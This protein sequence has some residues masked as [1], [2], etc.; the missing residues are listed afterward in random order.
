MID[1]AS[2]QTINC[3]SCNHPAKVCSGSCQECLHEIHYWHN[4]PKPIRRDCY[5]CDRL[6]F[7]Y[8]KSY[9]ERYYQNILS[10]CECIDLSQFDR[11][12]ILSIG[13]GASPDLMAFEE[14]ARGRQIFYR[15]IDKIDQWHGFHELIMSY[16]N[17]SNIT[18]DFQQSDIFNPVGRKRT[19]IFNVVVMQYLISSIWCGLE[20]KGRSRSCKEQEVRKV[21][22]GVIET[23]LYRWSESRCPTPFLIIINDNDSAS[24]GR[25]QFY[26]LLDMLVENDYY[27][28]AYINSNFIQDDMSD[29]DNKGF[30]GFDFYES[31][32]HSNRSATLTIEVRK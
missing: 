10:A 25:K 32:N 16:T 31:N 27:G 30:E 24:T 9:T 5:G 6:V 20:T 28:S 8:V 18:V 3:H 7:E 1:W 17:N 15:G 14:L 26:D 21:F 4:N 29:R 22:A 23:A 13:C 2:Q 12:N 19:E 11:F